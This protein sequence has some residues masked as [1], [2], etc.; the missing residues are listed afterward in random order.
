MSKQQ[1]FD[2]ARKF[3]AQ[4]GGFLLAAEELAKLGNIEDA[5]ARAKSALKQAQDEL[6]AHADNRARLTTEAEA[7][8][9][10]KRAEGDA[11]LEAKKSEAAG[12]VSG[13]KVEADRIKAAAR[14][15]AET[16]TAEAVAA[17]EGH[18]AKAATLTQ[19][20]ADLTQEHA[21]AT[22]AL[23][24]VGGKIADTK[25]EHQRL[26]LAHEQFLASIMKS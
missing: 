16:I 20:I 15:D 3:A 4:F 6:D 12:I 21:S 22:A 1:I 8:A 24:E 9:T 11:H 13:A 25:A 7:H 18:Q 19:A 26:R 5:I 23:A 2:D 14:R 10:A 17:V